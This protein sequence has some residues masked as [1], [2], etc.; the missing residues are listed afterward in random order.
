MINYDLENSSIC[1]RAIG[2]TVI[3]KKIVKRIDV[4]NNQTVPKQH[5][6]SLSNP[7]TEQNPVQPTN[8]QRSISNSES[9][10]ETTQLLAH[11]IDNQPNNLTINTGSIKKTSPIN[12]TSVS[13][14]RQS[15]SDLDLNTSPT[16]KQSIN[17]HLNSIGSNILGNLNL[18]DLNTANAL[19]YKFVSGLPDDTLVEYPFITINQFPIGFIK[20]IGGVVSS[21]SVKHLSMLNSQ[22]D[23]INTE[24][25]EAW[26]MELR[27]EIRNH[28][29]ML[30]CTAVLGYSETITI[31]D[32]VA[33]LSGSGTA[34]T[35]NTKSSLKSGSVDN[36][37]DYNSPNNL[38][39]T[40]DLED[41][42]DNL[43]PIPINLTNKPN[44]TLCHIPYAD[45][46]SL[47]GSSLAKCRFCGKSKV[48]DVIFATIQPP[49]NMPTIG[50]GTL[51]QARVFRN[52]KDTRAKELSDSLPFLEYEMHKQLLSK[53]K[54]KNMNSIFNLNVQ[55]SVGDSTLIALATGTGLFLT[56]LQEPNP[57]KVKGSSKSVRMTRLN[58]IQKMIF[59][60][61][62]RN[63]ERYDLLNLSN[64]L[65]PVLNNLQTGNELNN[66]LNSIDGKAELV[67]PHALIQQ[68][69]ISANKQTSSD[70]CVVL[71]IDDGDEADIS[72]LLDTEIPSNIELCNTD[73]LPGNEPVLSIYNTFNK[74]FRAKI[75]NSKQFS[76][77][78]DYIMQSLF[79]KLRRLTP[80]C[81]SGLRFK[82]EA[83]AEDNIVQ[84]TVFGS[85]VG[86]KNFNQ[87]LMCKKGL[88]LYLPTHCYQDKKTKFSNDNEFVFESEEENCEKLD[89]PS[90]ITSVFKLQNRGS[91]ASVELTT[92]SY[93]PMVVFGEFFCFR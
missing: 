41:K 8:V 9:I 14:F 19:E 49:L 55:I 12:T 87:S 56:P 74:V 15:S 52:K 35:L 36:L 57:I 81:L 2:T 82:I 13:S 34:V 27:K 71:E 76:A 58:D 50:K 7:L 66:Q 20:S 86:L 38:N 53:L 25:R 93:L 37:N 31:H 84:I 44:C 18:D 80:C 24:S 68:T 73:Y 32:D 11:P 3:L 21:R 91:P 78:F 42:N 62:E 6:T 17:N 4:T 75:T 48:P 54:L 77:Q 1:V 60:L 85:V 10:E 45:K 90:T 88:N 39:K 28:C 43:S 72:L 29:R 5:T 51:I 83:G 89:L 92:L 46:P 65:N 22:E 63:K 30:N 23:L 79:V 33:I 16:P 69:N 47:F 61:V 67:S 70:N 64:R 26:L 59:D 40:F